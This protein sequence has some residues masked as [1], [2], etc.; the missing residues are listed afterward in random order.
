MTARQSRLPAHVGIIM[1]G[2]GRWAKKRNLPRIAG[3]KQGAK[4]FGNIVR[5]AERIGLQYLTVY[6]F[7]TENWQRPAEEIAGIMNLLREYLR[8]VE[9]YRDENIRVQIIGDTRRLDAD[10]R[11]DIMRIEAHTK[12]KAG[13]HLNL[14]IGY[15][16]RDEL[17]RAARNIA[18]DALAGKLENLGAIDDALVSRYL[19]TAGQPDVD[20]IIR[21]SGEIRTSNFLLWQSAY[22]EYLFTDV[23]WPDFSPKEF[24]KALAEYASRSR[25]MGGV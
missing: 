2:N 14:A 13:L 21:T 23:L 10:I 4:A 7:S 16:G 12:D 15:G 17:A 8:D 25:R 18:A 22:A 3:H 9:R 20:L 5:H 1:D 11:A 6:A 24:D 19:Y